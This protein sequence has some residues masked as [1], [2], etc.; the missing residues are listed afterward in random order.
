MGLNTRTIQRVDLPMVDGPGFDAFA[1]SR[2]ST[3]A[4]LFEST[5]EYGK[6]PLVWEDVGSGTATHGANSRGVALSVA[7]GETITRQTFQ[8]HRYQPGKSQLIVMSGVLGAVAADITQRIGYFDD[9]NGVFLEQSSSGLYCVVR[10]KTSGSV[11]NTK[12]EQADWNRS[13][14]DW[15]DPT[16]SNI[17]WLDFEWLGTGRVRVGFYADGIPVPVHEF[18]N[19]NV[20]ATPYMQTANLPMRYQLVSGSTGTA[21]DM[22]QVCGAVIS[23][24]GIDVGLGLLIS[25]DNGITAATTSTTAEAIL[26]VRPKT[27]FNSI[28]NRINLIFERFQIYALGQDTRYAVIYGGTLG[29]TP[30]WSDVNTTHSSAEFSEDIEAVSGGVELL[31][32]YLLAGGVGQ[33]GRADITQGILTRIPATQDSAGTA[34]RQVSL[35]CQALA[36]TGTALGSLTWV[37]SH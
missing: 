5:S 22:L 8:Y 7:G 24:G 15:F 11:V 27:T 16:K 28:T 31:T 29:G 6:S 17:L 19:A 26:T 36:S 1:R 10:T 3:A 14:A 35:V 30:T 23:E 21:S 12:I 25:A 37:E 2:V 18:N 4:T 33:G 34:G 20:Y 9:D 13:N 32:G